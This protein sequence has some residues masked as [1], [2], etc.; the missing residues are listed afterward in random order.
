MRKKGGELDELPGCH[1]TPSYLVTEEWLEQ[2]PGWDHQKPKREERGRCRGE[3]GL[4]PWSGAECLSQSLTPCAFH[5]VEGSWAEA[6]RQ[7]GVKLP[8]CSQEDTWS[9]LDED[10]A[11][12]CWF[13]SHFCYIC[14]PSPT[15]KTGPH[16]LSPACGNLSRSAAGLV[17]C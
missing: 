1:D 17:I 4:V 13:V 12:S 14:C 16:S 6:H 2:N 11:P 10:T 15:S 5:P 8:R 9:W 7:G 3:K